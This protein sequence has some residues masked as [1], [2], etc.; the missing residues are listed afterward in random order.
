MCDRIISI[1]DACAKD[2]L[3]TVKV[4]IGGCNP[5][6]CESLMRVAITEDAVDVLYFLI[7]KFPETSRRKSVLKH[8]IMNKRFSIYN[9]LVG[10]WVADHLVEILETAYLFDQRAVDVISGGIPR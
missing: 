9:A 10:P 7:E 4:L 1:F 2:D 8:A 3:E 5:D 6:L